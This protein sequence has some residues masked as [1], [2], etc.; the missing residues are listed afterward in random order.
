[1]RRVRAGA[2][3]G[4][5]KYRGSSAQYVWNRLNAVDFIN[6]GILFAATLLLCFIPFLIVGNALAGRS[7]AHTLARHTGV[8]E[9]AANDFSHLFAPSAATYHAVVGTAS[10]VFFVLGGI[11]AATALQ[12]LYER[13]FGL[14]SRGLRDFGRRLLFLAWLV[15]GAAVTG[16]IAPAIHDALG[17][18][19]I[20][21]VG[22]VWTT[23]FWWVTLR[24]LVG[25][26]VSQ[27]LFPP[28]FATGVFYIGMLYVFSLFFSDMVISQDKEYGPIGLIF[29][30]M[31]FLIAVGVVIILGAV[32]GLAWQE[33]GLSVAAGV[34]K[35]TG[36]R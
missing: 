11:A 1:V 34:R 6:L 8:N 17:P 35:L 21:I 3:W 36:R 5:E 20:A 30:L 22:V 12:Q 25:G 26:R 16:W 24:I 29:A 28:A 32:V 15:G 2:D 18:V 14:E 27:R 10:M 31:A 13:V 19:L 4:R 33:R 9:Q 7:T 23:T